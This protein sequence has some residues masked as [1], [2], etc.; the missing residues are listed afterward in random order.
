MAELP[1]VV[2]CTAREALDL[3]LTVQTSVNVRTV[4]DGDN[5]ESFDFNLTA[6]S[7][8]NIRT[9]RTALEIQRSKPVVRTA[10]LISAVHVS[11]P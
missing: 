1:E 4:R 6:Q 8:V 2:R 7:C 5:C 9:V 11:S 10:H 3:D